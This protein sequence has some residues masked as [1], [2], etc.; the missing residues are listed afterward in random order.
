MLYHVGVD[1][2]FFVA[3]HQIEVWRRREAFPVGERVGVPVCVFHL[4]AL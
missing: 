1:P 2:A 3:K 4:Y